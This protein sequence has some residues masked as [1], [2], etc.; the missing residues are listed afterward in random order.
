MIIKNF[1][2]SILLL[3]IS[4]YAIEAQE[5]EFLMQA[6]NEAYQ[7]K[8]FEEAVSNY[9]AILKQGYLSSDLYYNLGNSYFRLDHI[10]KAI[11]NYERSL[12]ISPSNE[13]A[14][15]NLRLANARTVDKIQELP[16]LFFI[17]W[18]NIL[19]ATFTSTGWQIIIFIF[20]ILLLTCIAVYFLV[21]NLQVQKFAF[22]FGSLNIVALIISVIFIE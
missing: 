15:Y 18:W 1:I 5:L 17:N 16:D 6:G 4:T 10:G 14:I 7:N 21:R 11:L 22:I 2:F 3:I 12:K 9:E 19:L 8:N 13:D 20:Y